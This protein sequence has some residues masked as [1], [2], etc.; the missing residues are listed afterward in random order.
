MR[1]ENQQYGCS[2]ESVESRDV[3]KSARIILFLGHGEGS[4]KGFGNHR[5]IS[6]L[7]KKVSAPKR[8]WPFEP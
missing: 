7:Y 6:E 5:G 2:A 8:C 4:R 1:E 3:P